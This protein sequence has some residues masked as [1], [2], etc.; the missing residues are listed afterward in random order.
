MLFAAPA[1]AR[2][3]CFAEMLDS[4]GAFNEQLERDPRGVV[5]RVEAELAHEPGRA[6]AGYDRGQLYAVLMDAYEGVGDVAAA[7]Q[8]AA[9][10]LDALTPT[11]S[12]ALRRRLQL[13]AIKL[14]EQQGQIEQAASEYENAS[15]T[16]PEDAPDLVCVLG[17]RGYLRYLAGRSVEAAADAMRA[18]RLA[19]DQ[20]HHE[21]QLSAGQLLARLYS[22]YGL[23]DEAQ[24]L[25]D[26]A[27]TYYAHSEKKAQ[28]ADAYL[29]RGD[30]RLNKEDFVAAD[31]DFRM[32]RD[33]LLA[34][35]D[36][37]ARSFT[38]QRLC[39]VAARMSERADAPAA[40]RD[41]FEL[42]EAVHN[43]V[44]AKIVL[45]ALGLI[46]FDRGR[47]KEAVALWNRVL[48]RDG[49]DV[50]K[51]VQVRVHGL[52]GRARAELGDTAGALQDRNV[53]IEALEA[54][55]KA[56]T[57]GQVALLTVKFTLDL[58]DEEVAKARAEARAAELAAARQVLVRNVVVAAA[59]AA[60]ALA[61]A[62]LAAWLWHRRR[63]ALDARRAVDE[64]LAAIG[65][66]TGG[67]AHEFNNL[68]SVI[69]Q[70]LGL[71]AGR[72]AVV[73]DAA[74]VGLVQQA[75]RASQ[76]CADITSQLLSF[77]RQ[78]NLKP[79]AIEV[80]Q[81]LRDMQPLLE[82]AA[83][84]AV[85]V[86]VETQGTLTASVDRRQLTA[87]LLNLVT[88]ARDAMPGGDTVTVRASADADR[89]VRID[90]I[91]TG[92]GMA[93][94]VLARAVEPFYSTK[95]VGDGSGLGLSMVQG[96]VTQSG[97][98]LAITS[99][100]GQGTTVSLWLPAAG[101]ARA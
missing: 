42:A 34:T 100:V 76:F 39:T 82:H 85:K 58:K 16:V 48:A 33:I 65:R 91:D 99:T 32:S 36:R 12:A 5:T 29:F 86:A 2:A 17:D 92:A 41:A 74:A 87:A 73:R 3:G 70:A 97:G 50:P 79:E 49:I 93:P 1:V 21:I 51:S 25:A 24:A 14:L 60:A 90:V 77:A 13:T 89:H 71:L 59:L 62:I 37:A 94:D 22:Q 101:A 10:G 9:R 20:G 68:L 84:S 75:R 40:C 95:T 8:A 15:A 30:V 31:A 44:T 11:D 98:R 4:N 88:N 67:V 35:G 27:V 38:E 64:R 56:R 83:G 61:G 81:C 96:F 47:P 18:Y 78:Q 69:Q 7:R 28:L 57:A 46:A 43:P 52:R 6:G 19:R 54:D 80:D 26:E 72:D 45:A 53:Y 66:L 63:L 55:R 23:Y